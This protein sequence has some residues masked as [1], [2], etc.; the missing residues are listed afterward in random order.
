MD[1]ALGL[2]CRRR[3]VGVV[4]VRRCGVPRFCQLSRFR[5]GGETFGS[6]VMVLWCSVCTCIILRMDGCG[7]GWMLARNKPDVAAALYE[8]VAAMAAVTQDVDRPGDGRGV[9]FHSAAA[10]QQ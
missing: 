10:A 8:P 4:E 3:V 6:V 9:V 2:V 5:T 7:E 1:C